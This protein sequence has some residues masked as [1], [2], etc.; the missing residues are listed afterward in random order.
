[1]ARDMMELSR[2]DLVAIKLE[3]SLAGRKEEVVV[4]SAYMPYDAP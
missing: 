1:M 2:R 4:A 3:I